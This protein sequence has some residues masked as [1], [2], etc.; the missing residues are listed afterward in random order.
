MDGPGE[1]VAERFKA[2]IDVT[3][4]LL[5]F[6]RGPKA[7]EIQ[8]RPPEWYEEIYGRSD[9]E[10]SYDIYDPFSVRSSI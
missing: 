3:R 4:Y 9:D 8:Q 5:M 7:E 1:V 10:N 6:L 2:G